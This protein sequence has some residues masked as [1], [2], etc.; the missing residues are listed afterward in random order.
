LRTGWLIERDRPAEAADI[1]WALWPFWFIRG[2]LAEGRSW[3]E[4]TLDLPSLPPAAESR[5]LVGAALMCYSQAELG[6]ART[7]LNRAVAVANDVDDADVVALAENL[8]DASNTPSAT[9]TLPAHSSPTALNG[10]G[11][12]R[13]RGASGV[14]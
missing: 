13:S 7:R 3:Y 2:H 14:P 5:A 6:L 12:C 1:A 4:K 9:W 8:P 10:T 11:R